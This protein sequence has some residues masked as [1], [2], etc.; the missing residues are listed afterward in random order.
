LGERALNLIA[1]TISVL[2][3]WWLVFTGLLAAPPDTSLAFLALGL[4]V[5]LAVGVFIHEAG[6]LFVGLALGVATRKIRVGS[7]PTLFTFRPRGVRVQICVNPLGG[8]AVYLSGLDHSSRDVRIVT[9]AAGPVTNVIAA[10]YGLVMV[11]FGADWLG[12]FALVNVLLGVT[13]LIPHQFTLDGRDQPND[14]MQILQ[15]V[16]GTAKKGLYFEGVELAADAQTVQVRALEEARDEGSAEVTDMHLLLGLAGDRDVRPL[17]APVDMHSVLR[18]AGPSTSE[19]VRPIWAPVTDQVE[20]AAFRVARD[21]GRAKPDAA[22]MCLGLMA[23][24]CPAGRLLKESG[25][26]EAAQRALVTSRPEPSS[27]REI[28]P[29]MVDLPVERWG[30]AADR[31]VTLAA[32]IAAADRSTYIGTEHLVAALVAEPTSRA[33]RALDRLGFMLARED[34]TVLKRDVPAGQVLSPQAA[35]AMA[36]ALGRTAPTYPMGTGELCLGI[37]DQGSGMGAMLL[38]GA[39]IRTAD[40]V[41]ALRQQERDPGD[42]LGCTLASRRMWEL[43]ASARLGAQRYEEARADFIV[44]EQSAPSDAVRALDRNNIAWTSL[45][46]GDPTLSAH[47]LELARAAVGFDPERLAYKGTLAFALME[48]GSVAEAAALLEP[49]ASTHP[50]P[51]DR[52]LDLCLLAIC[53][54][55]LHQSEAAAKHLE[56]AE[57]ADSRCQLLD[58]ARAEIAQSSAVA[59][60]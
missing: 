5:S 41:K 3:T 59:I 16:L 1:P 33:A 14:G 47:A 40:L 60:T 24:D 4:F 32:R 44:L 56:A 31:T 17:L 7:G 20:Q 2:F 26:S 9:T 6:H 21:L 58:R 34:R 42:P 30:S 53:N 28:T 27:E 29:T 18:A 23:V 55:R 50:R 46:S 10:L 13:N 54:A 51:R 39:G 36:A 22:C 45:M 43:R 38:M 15:N 37:A 8:G 12:L 52:A 57:A 35:A 49:V 25:V 48:N 11:H 19:E